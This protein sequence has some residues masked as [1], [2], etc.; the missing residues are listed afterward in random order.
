MFGIVLKEF[1]FISI[2]NDKPSLLIFVLFIESIMW[3][4]HCARLLTNVTSNL[5]NN[6]MRAGTIVSVLK[7][8]MRS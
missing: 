5:H 3:A 4:E 6:R 8:K 1:T 2:N 7:V